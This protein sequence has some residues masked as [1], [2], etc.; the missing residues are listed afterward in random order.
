M[1]TGT[2]AN[3]RET[4]NKVLT[5][6][7]WKETFEN[8][9]S[10][11]RQRLKWFFSP[12]GCDS[13]GYLALVSFFDPGAA[14][15]ALGVFQAICQASATFRSD[16]RG[17]F[18]NTDGT[19]MELQQIS[20][21]IRVPICHLSASLEI[22][23]DKRVRWC[24]WEQHG[25]QSATNL[26]VTCHQSASFV[27]GQGKGEGKGQGQGQGEG[28]P[29]PPFREDE[30]EDS[31]CDDDDPFA[32]LD[33]PPQEQVRLAWNAMAETHGLPKVAKL[34]G[35]RQRALRARLKDDYWAE[36]WR[37]ALVLVPKNSFNLGQ[38]ERQWRANIDWFIRENTVPKLI[39]T[40]SAPPARTALTA[41]GKFGI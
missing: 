25:E 38:N 1:D 19:P 31:I 27:Q 18:V 20:V 33:D 4:C 41:I 16:L 3:E 26:P 9:D 30:E 6:A 11:K 12:S 35:T 34:T 23:T 5:I 39:E 13:R 28:T 8:A 14:M 40:E 21:L 37:E 29:L 36:H 2:I 7:G 22:L 15:Q 17:T 32:Y 24:R 10:R